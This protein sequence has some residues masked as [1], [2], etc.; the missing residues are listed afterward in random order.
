MR[1]TPRTILV[2]G[3]AGFVGG[4]LLPALAAAF[5]DAALL[6]PTFD[7]RNAAEVDAAVRETPPDVAIH[8]AAVAAIAEAQNAPDRAWQVNLHGTM[9]LAWALSKHAPDC[10]M[11]FV[12]SADA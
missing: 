9:H 5:P 8:L 6:T 3:A 2:T 12:S 1:T 7:I 4:H 10:Q 11:L